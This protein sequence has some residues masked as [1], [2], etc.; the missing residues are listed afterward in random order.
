M[1]ARRFSFCR[2]KAPVSAI[3]RHM[4]GSQAAAEDD[5]YGGSGSLR[6]CM[7][8]AGGRLPHVELRL[9]FSRAP[10]LS[11]L[12]LVGG[13]WVLLLSGSGPARVWSAAAAQLRAEGFPLR[14]LHIVRQAHTLE[15]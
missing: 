5:D 7:H 10:S 2:C 15:Q 14:R 11:L 13:Q 9:M 3:C 12:D 8:A 6:R 4:E 1:R